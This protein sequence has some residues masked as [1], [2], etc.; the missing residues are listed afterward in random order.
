LL[1]VG[2][3]D[4]GTL[5]LIDLLVALNCTPEMGTAVSLPSN[6]SADNRTDRCRRA[7]RDAGF[8]HQPSSCTG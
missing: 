8:S 6:F 2:D 1:E 7:S 4:V 3:D 5:R